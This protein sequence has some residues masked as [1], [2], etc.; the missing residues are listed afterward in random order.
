MSSPLVPEATLLCLAVALLLAGASVGARTASAL[1]MPQVLGQLV[2]GLLLGPSVLGWFAPDAQH[3]LFPPGGTLAELAHLALL[4]VVGVSAL[5]MSPA[6]IRRHAGR[7]LLVCAPAFLLP[8]ALGIGVGLWAAP[9]L[10]TDTETWRFTLV[11]G[12]VLAVSAVP[13][14]IRILSELGVAHQLWAQVALAAAVAMDLVVWL[15]FSAAV[16][17]TGTGPT[18]VSLVLAGAS[19]AVTA[20]LVLRINRPGRSVPHAESCT[21]VIAVLCG[22]ATAGLLGLDGVIG[23]FLVGVCAAGAANGDPAQTRALD[24]TV[25]RLLAPLAFASMGLTIDL[26]ALSPGLV[27]VT[28]A[29][30]GLALVSKIVGGWAGGRLAGFERREARAIGTLLSARGAMEIMLADLALRAGVVDAGWHAV[31]MTIG[32]ATSVVAGPLTR[33]AVSGLPVPAEDERGH[34]LVARPDPDGPG[35]SL[36]RAA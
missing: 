10:D 27:L 32:I 12:V 6:I 23:A 5:E 16:G 33:L 13:V 29:L 1:R 34:D 18:V 2:S 4:V 19:L 28:V 22:A 20:L 8:L 25:S 11:I 15:L 35:E 14:A 17:S 24:E 21:L 26:G 7:V 36:D 31:I 9:S 30:V 3:A